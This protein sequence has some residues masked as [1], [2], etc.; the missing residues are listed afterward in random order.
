MSE[1]F[2]MGGYAF[3]VWGSFGA[4]AAVL[5]WNVVAPLRARSRVLQR[6]R[7]GL[8]S[9]ERPPDYGSRGQA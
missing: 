5:A 8:T 4:G 6:L 2:D 3:Y 7:S 9:A 1:F